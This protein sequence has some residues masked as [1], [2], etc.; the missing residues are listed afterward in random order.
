MSVNKLIG[1]LI[2]LLLGVAVVTFLA[3]GGIEV[4]AEVAQQLAKDSASIGCP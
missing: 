3:C 1:G 4:R 2:G